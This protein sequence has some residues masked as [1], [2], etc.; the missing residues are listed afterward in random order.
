MIELENLNDKSAEEIFD[1]A[2]KRISI[3]N[4]EWNYQ[5][6]SDPGITLL[7]LLSWLKYDQEKYL[8]SISNRLKIKL[9][10]LLGIE[11]KKRKGSKTILQ[12][13]NSKEDVCIPKGTKWIHDSLVFEN[14]KME[15]ITKSDILSIKINNPESIHEKKY[16]DVNKAEGILIFGK[17]NVKIGENREFIIILSDKFPKDRQVNFYFE[18]F[19]RYKRNKIY[20]EFIPF[21]KLKWQYWGYDGSGIKWIDSDFFDN[22]NQFLNSG[23]VSI[24][25]NSDMVPIDG[26]YYLKCKLIES[27]YDFMPEIRNVII[28]SFEVVQKDT[29]CDFSI[30]KR[31]DIRIENKNIR[32]KVSN[33]LCLYGDIILY[34]KKGEHW[35]EIDK[36]KLSRNV[37]SGFC[38]FEI[39]DCDFEDNYEFLVIC[40]SKD[41]KEKII[42]GNG[43]GFSNLSFNIDFKD[44]SVYDDFK[45]M[46]G[47]RVKRKLGFKIWERVDDFF[48]SSKFDN[49]FVYEENVKI[50]AF[51]DNHHGSVPIKEN[52]NIRFC[53]LSFTQAENSNLMSNVIKD[54]ITDNEII[55]NS[56]ITQI[57][58]ATGGV[59]EESLKNISK[60][61]FKLFDD[62]KRAILKEDYEKIVRN[63]PGLILKSVSISLEPDK[64][65]NKVCIAVQ[66]PGLDYIT[67]SYK[68]NILNWIE[69][70]RIINTDIRVI[71]PLV[72][73]LDIKI[74]VILNSEHMSENDNIESELKKFV[75]NLNK[76]MG[77][78][79][80][81]GDLFKKIENLK[82]VKYLENLEISSSIQDFKDDS[83]YDN[84]TV[85]M[86]SIYEIRKAD[87]ISLIDTDF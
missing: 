23:I 31:K 35:F 71:G 15:F 61:V 3:V 50:L 22:T 29:K 26:V 67:E 43:T 41:V 10:N 70:S 5:Q 39:E 20:K 34:I 83:H 59:E 49:H 55:K 21:A 11:L 14:E 27:D 68:N 52:N 85:P 79:L 6:E 7:E 17:N 80:I 86:N 37:K 16:Y 74:K 84:I 75:E 77:Q 63:T 76:K 12:I 57:I 69:N 18:I 25:N 24:R 54:V 2:K 64:L 40:Y 30:V 42:I 44:F 36:F 56:N 78:D 32:F 66:I 81:Y 53:K 9:L 82:Y 1:K 33:N 62:E 13:R 46:V 19:S 8:N 47:E 73:F 60:E 72:V 38:T 45:I 87:I 65:S 28:N 4:P 58:P 48:K 51:G